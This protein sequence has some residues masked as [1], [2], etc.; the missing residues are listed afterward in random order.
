MKRK[1]ANSSYPKLA[2]S[3]N[4][5]GFAQADNVYSVYGVSPTITAHLG[6]QVGHQV[7]ILEPQSK[8]ELVAIWDEYNDAVISAD[9]ATTIQPRHQI[10]K[11]G[12]RLLLREGGDEPN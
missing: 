11:H 9:L 7:N 3:L 1:K 5:Y 4:K 10:P 12:L 2:G 8:Y 6:G